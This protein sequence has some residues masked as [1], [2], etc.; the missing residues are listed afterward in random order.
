MY[1]PTV[2]NILIQS[3]VGHSLQLEIRTYVRMSIDR[4]QTQ[5]GFEHFLG[6]GGEGSF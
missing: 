5:P 4:Q 3:I 6:G 1:E 2:H